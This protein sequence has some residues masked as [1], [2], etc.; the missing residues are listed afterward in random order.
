MTKEEIEKQKQ[1]ALENV[2]KLADEA[3]ARKKEFDDLIEAA[4]GDGELLEQKTP[5]EGEAAYYSKASSDDSVKPTSRKPHEVSDQGKLLQA[6]ARESDMAKKQELIKRLEATFRPA[7]GAERKTTAY[8][9]QDG[10]IKA[11]PRATI[12]TPQY[13]QRMSDIT[14]SIVNENDG[15]QIMVLQANGEVRLVDLAAA[16]LANLPPIPPSFPPNYVYTQ[17]NGTPP[18]SELLPMYNWV[19]ITANYSFVA[20]STTI[21]QIGPPI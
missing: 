8:T 1:A 10:V 18:P 11:T 20:P 17:L 5:A 14:P 7:G 16:I 2:A 9:V 15:S 3:A 12:P 4:K 21:W 6:I 13:A 19:N